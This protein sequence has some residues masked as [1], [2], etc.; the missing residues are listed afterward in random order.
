MLVVVGVGDSAAS[1]GGRSN[2]ASAGGGG[3]GGGGQQWRIQHIL[4]SLKPGN[5]EPGL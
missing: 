5:Y 2:A 3:G 1:A 4:G